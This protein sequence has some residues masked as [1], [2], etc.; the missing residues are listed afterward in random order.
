M[1]LYFLRGALPWSG[2]DAK[3]QEEKYQKI[4]AKKRDTPIPSL[5]NFKVNG[6][7]I[8]FPEE[9]EKYLD[10]CRKLEFDRRPDYD[11]LQKLFADIRKPEWKDHDFEWLEKKPPTVE[12]VPLVERG[13]APYGKFQ[14]PD[15]KSNGNQ[16]SKG[17]CF[18][19]C[20]KASN[21]RD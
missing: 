16:Q 10:Y 17:S 6:E 19:L 1:F 15:E 5:N 21:T 7:T 11:M 14:Q 4:C 2:L 8:T 20:G 3:T 13:A 12:L 18:C 9:F